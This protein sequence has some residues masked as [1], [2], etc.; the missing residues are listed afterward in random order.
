M[1][2]RLPLRNVVLLMS[3]MVFV[4]VCHKAQGAPETVWHKILGQV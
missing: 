2:T 1:A 3:A 4:S